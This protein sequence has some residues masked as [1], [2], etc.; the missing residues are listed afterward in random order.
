MGSNTFMHGMAWEDRPLSWAASC[1]KSIL[2]R[3]VSDYVIIIWEAWKIKLYGHDSSQ[4]QSP[5]EDLG[6]I[7]GIEGQSGKNNIIMCQGGKPDTGKLLSSCS[8]L[9]RLCEWVRGQ[10]RVCYSSGLSIIIIIISIMML[11]A[12]AHGPPYIP[13]HFV[14]CI[15][16]S[17]NSHKISLHR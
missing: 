5:A 16:L 9:L 11:R 17:I 8:M 15:K 4:S 1:G 13:V 12:M 3:L 6:D 7:S 14:Q 2:L 10:W